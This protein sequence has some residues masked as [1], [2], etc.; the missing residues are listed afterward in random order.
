[1]GFFVLLTVV[2]LLRGRQRKGT[3][4]SLI[5]RKQWE[6]EETSRFSRLTNA[7]SKKLEFLV[8]AV[9]LHFG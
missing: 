9:N 6:S 4:M 2:Q 7:F 5:R 1:M 8:A 3:G